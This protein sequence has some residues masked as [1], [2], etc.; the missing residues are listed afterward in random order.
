[1]DGV[2]SRSEAGMFGSVSGYL[3]IIEAQMRKMLHLHML[4]QLHGFSRPDDMFRRGGLQARIT[5]VWRFVA[6]ICFR[7]TDAFVRF[8]H[9]DSAI[10]STQLSALMPQNRKQ[11]GMTGE[12]AVRT[13]VEAQLAARG[14][15]DDGSGDGIRP[16]PF[17]KP[18]LVQYMSQTYASTTMSNA[19]YATTALLDTHAAVLNFETIRAARTFVKG[20]AALVDLASAA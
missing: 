4:V 9:E 8:L 13:V 20:D 6:S 17:L 11:R 12:A 16:E 7:S 1:M 18:Q 14:L 5:E 19:D 3:G 10:R 2:A 15:V